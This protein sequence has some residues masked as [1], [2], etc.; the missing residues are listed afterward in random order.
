LQYIT[1]P[2]ANEPDAAPS[3]D[4]EEE[5]EDEEESKDFCIENHQC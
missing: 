4:E 3:D 5:E 2:K 1:K